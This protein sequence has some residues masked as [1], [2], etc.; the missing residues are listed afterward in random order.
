MSRMTRKEVQK[1]AVI[2]SAFTALALA[3]FVAGCSTADANPASRVT[4]ARFGNVG[5]E[6]VRVEISG[7]GSNSVSVTASVTIGDN[8]LASADSSG[9]TETTSP[10]QTPTNSTSVP[11]TVK[12]NDVISG[13]TQ[14]SQSVLGSI[15]T[16]IEAVLQLMASGKTGTVN[17][18][19][20][21]GTPATVQ[22]ADGQCSFCSDGACAP[23]A[24]KAVKAPG[25]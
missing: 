3:A 4:S 12:Y 14:A 10:T 8:A 25:K 21:D 6:L 11:I 1:S 15:G 9:S 7:G 13:A 23:R 22:C 20:L 2:A 17:V 16:G 18:T 19:T 5:E 24:V